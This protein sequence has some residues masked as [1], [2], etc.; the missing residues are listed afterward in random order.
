MSE[1]KTAASTVPQQIIV[2]GVSGV[3]KTTVAHGIA[4]ATGWQIAEGD[5]FHPEANVAKMAAGIPL[6]DGDRWPWLR[7]IA[8]WMDTQI[9]AGKPSVITCSALRHAYR[10][11][12]RENRPEVVFLHLTADATLV[13]DRINGRSGHFMPAS[14]LPTQYA[15]LEPLG[16][17]EPGVVVS[18]EGDVPQVVARAMA[19]LNLPLEERSA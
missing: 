15:T 16:P 5:E 1:E 19:A 10:D 11:L 9:A 4:E 8:D 2:M 12:L 7:T 13:E 6:N 18:V 14:L 3:G 17:D